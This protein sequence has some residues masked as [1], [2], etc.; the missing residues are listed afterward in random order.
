M[1]RIPRASIVLLAVGLLA[2][3]PASV[4]AADPGSGAARVLGGRAWLGIA[5]E[6]AADAAGVRVKH[7]LRGSPAE[8]AGLKDGDLIR[9]IDG[10]K[11]ASPDD[12]SRIVGSHEPGEGIVASL[13]RAQDSLSMKIALASRPAADE[14]LRMDRVGAERLGGRDDPLAV[15]IRFARRSR[16]DAQRGVECVAEE[17]VLVGVGIDADR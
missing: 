4:S 3:A 11:V 16:S 14:M 12:V 6:R 8:K 2:L 10:E 17:R 13:S 7:V 9:A 5:M 15:E 1:A